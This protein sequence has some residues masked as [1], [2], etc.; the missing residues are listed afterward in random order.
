MVEKRAPS[1]IVR[2]GVLLVVLFWTLGLFIELLLNF[3][4]KSLCQ[5][6]S[7]VVVGEWARLSHREMV[8]LGLVYF[9]GLGGFLLGKKEGLLYLWASGGLFAETIFFLR[10]G[11]EYHLYCPF[12]LL[13]GLG[14]ALS[15]LPLLVFHRPSWGAL[16]G[17]LAGLLLGFALTATPLSALK[18]RAFP[19]FPDRPR[20]PDLLL[21]Y[22]PDCPHCHEVL[23]FCRHLPQANLYLCR[24][25]EALPLFRILGLSG[26]P[27]LIVDRPGRREILEGSR[28]II[29][30]LEKRFGGQGLS[31]TPLENGLF[32]PQIETGVCSELKPKCE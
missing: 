21:I 12:C 8:L 11:L 9:L 32:V 25:E 7:C 29:A 15:A 18:A 23:D 26:V 22:S 27:V 5:A 17:G 13:V 1:E 20:V 6:T 10:Q 16:L 28:A 31:L 30:Y 2:F 14:V 24:K 4:G 19:A 3:K